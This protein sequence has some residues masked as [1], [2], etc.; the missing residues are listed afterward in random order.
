MAKYI[1]QD[2]KLIHAMNE[3]L[4]IIL[5][6]PDYRSMSGDMMMKKLNLSK[7]EYHRLQHAIIEWNNHL[8]VLNIEITGYGEPIFKSEKGVTSF[9]YEDG[10]YIQIYMETLKYLATQEEDVE[11]KEEL[12]MAVLNLQ[13]KNLSKPII[14]PILTSIGNMASLAVQFTPL[15]KSILGL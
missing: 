5:E 6:L 15:A 1:R 8:E 3:F 7:E 2:Y 12:K 14:W 4:K 10:G 9:F 13:K 11:K